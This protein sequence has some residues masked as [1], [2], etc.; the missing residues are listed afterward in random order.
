[1]PVKPGGKEKLKE[2][3]KVMENAE[4]RRHKAGELSYDV[5]KLRVV[6]GM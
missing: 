6:L 3:L 2:V 5:N 4:E 1:M